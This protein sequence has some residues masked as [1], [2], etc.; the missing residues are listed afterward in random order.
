MNSRP[1]QCQTPLRLLCHLFQH[2]FF[3]DKNSLLQMSDWD[4]AQVIPIS[5]W[6]I[7]SLQKVSLSQC[8]AMSIFVHF[9]RG[10]INADGQLIRDKLSQQQLAI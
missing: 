3:S 4:E 2:L 5:K 8:I 6:V 9:R 7:T 10:Q 1:C